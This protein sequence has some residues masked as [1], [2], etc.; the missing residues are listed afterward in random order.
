V[1]LIMFLLTF[2]L[3]VFANGDS[4]LDRD[5]S[6]SGYGNIR[7]R[8]PINKNTK[9]PIVLFHG[10]YGGASHRTWRKILPL[11]DRAGERVFIMDLPGVGESDKPKRSYSIKDFDK[12][13]EKFLIEV[14][15]ERATLVS[16]SILSNGV[17]KISGER[18]DLVRRAVILNP[19]GITSLVDGPSPREE[20]LYNR[21]FNDDI[22][23]IAFYKNLLNPNSL[24]Y[25]LGF[26]FFNDALIDDALLSDFLAVRE[27]IDQRYLTL[28]FVG[29]QLFRSF[30]ESSQN[31]FIPVLAIFGKE[32]EGFQ[33]N[34]I[35]KAEDFK[36]I[37]PYFEYVEIEKSGSSVQ[38][39]KPLEVAKRIID[40]SILD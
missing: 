22:A 39:E 21:L 30:E 5:V 35:A 20:S 10:I 12:F 27:N 38:R 3:T 28:S 24:R 18:P 36:A 7:Y 33:D 32:Y 31:V 29:G 1:K 23:A 25:F 17:L 40:F 2:S 14:V 19:S 15:K 16:E 37:R 26:G 11:L 34:Q 8:A 6:V 13:V 9:K 4:L